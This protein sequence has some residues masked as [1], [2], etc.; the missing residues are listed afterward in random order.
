[1]KKGVRVPIMICMVMLIF[2]VLDLPVR[3]SR[4]IP[5]MSVYLGIK[6]A[7]AP[8][9]GLMLGPWGVIGSLLGAAFCG[10]IDVNASGNCIAYEFVTIIVEGLGAWLMWHA[11]TPDHRVR[12]KKFTDLLK[13]ILIILIVSTASAGASFLFVAGGD[14]FG[15]LLT[16]MISDMLLGIPAIIIYCG[17]MCQ[18]PVIPSWS[19][20][21]HDFE[22]S[23]DATEESYISFT[24]KLDELSSRLG[25]SKRRSFEVLNTIE[26]VYLRIRTHEPEETVRVTIDCGDALSILFEYNGKKCNPLRIS[27][28]EDLVALIGLKLIEHRAIRTSYKYASQVNKVLI[29]L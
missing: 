22:E 13:Y 26:E 5:E 23:I 20:R 8:A 6:N 4:F 28:D 10:L 3:F 16:H 27:A 25:L 7:L 12:F 18:D 11:V 19:T 2:I 24:E 9:T 21:T 1:M 29:V 15:V 17:I 14:F